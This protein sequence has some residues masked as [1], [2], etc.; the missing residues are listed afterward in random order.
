MG[1]SSLHVIP[2]IN[3]IQH[4]CFTRGLTRT[5]IAM[6]KEYLMGKEIRL[7]YYSIYEIKINDTMWFLN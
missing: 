7:A 4:S 1:L 6:V 5:T 3:I 2:F